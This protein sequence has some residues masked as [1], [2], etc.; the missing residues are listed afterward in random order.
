MIL[1]PYM[2]NGDLLSYIRDAKNFLTIKDLLLLAL[3]IAKGKKFI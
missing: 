1:M 2:A 3:G